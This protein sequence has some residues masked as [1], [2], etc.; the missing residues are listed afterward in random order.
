MRQR[1]R[2]AMYGAGGPDDL[3]AKRFANRLVPEADAE[4]RDLSCEAAYRRN[5]NSGI[6]GSTRPGRD[7]DSTAFTFI[8]FI[9]CDRVVAEDLRIGSEL[10]EVLHE[11]VGER[12]EVVDDQQHTYAPASAMAMAFCSARDLFSVSSYSLLGC[13]SATMPAPACTLATPSRNSIVRIA[14]HESKLPA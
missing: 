6:G 3:A 4:D 12:I 11:V 13:E 9:Q 10:A 8:N 1:A 7:H 5:R 14:I 2:F